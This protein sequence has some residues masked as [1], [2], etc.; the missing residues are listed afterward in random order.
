[1]SWQQLSPEQAREHPLYG[2]AGWLLFL[3]GVV[4]F[5][6]I[7]DAVEWAQYGPGSD[8]P[9]WLLA[10]SIAVNLAILVAGV[11]HWRW[12]PELAIAGIWIVGGLG[13]L[14]TQH[15]AVAPVAGESEIDP[16]Q[17]G[18]AAYLAFSLLL[19]WLLLKSERVNVTFKH[20]C[21]PAAE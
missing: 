14:Y 15:A 5:A 13:Q 11:R 2:I 10:L 8:R 16:R 3:F 7:A 6:V 20:R 9:V 1:M 4:I 21:R 19:T 17:V 12:F 18:I